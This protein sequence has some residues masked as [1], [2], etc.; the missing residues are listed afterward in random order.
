MSALAGRAHPVMPWVLTT[1]EKHEIRAHLETRDGSGLVSASAMHALEELPRQAALGARLT[2]RVQV[3]RTTAKLACG[4]FTS[5]RGPASSWRGAAGL[6]P[7]C[8][9]W[10]NVVNAADA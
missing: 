6:C 4:H 5:L 1:Q 7:T 2:A 9:Q 8:G 10:R 3:R